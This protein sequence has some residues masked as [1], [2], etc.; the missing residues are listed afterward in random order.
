MTDTISIPT[1]EKRTEVLIVGAGPTGL[2]LALFLKKRGI[3]FRIIDRNQGPGTTSRAL[4]VQARTLEFYRQLGIDQKIISEGVLAKEL[5]FLRSGK[6]AVKVEFG[7]IG[8]GESPYPYLLFL[9]Q[10]VHEEILVQELARVGVEIERNTSLKEFKEIDNRVFAVLD[11]PKGEEKVQAD[12]L[13]GCD[14]AHSAVRHGMN[15]NFPGGTYAQVFFVAD[16][17][18][19]EERKEAVQVSVSR[20]DFCILMPIQQKASIRLTGLVPPGSENKTEIT[21]KDVSAAVQNNLGLSITKINWFSSYRVHHRVVDSFRKGR[22]FLAGDAAHIHSPAGGQGMNTGIGDAVNLAWKIAEVLRGSKIDNR[23]ELLLSSYNAERHT[24]ARV[25]VTTTDQAFQVIASRSWLG[26]I[27]RCYIIPTLLAYLVRSR[28]IGRLMFRT[29][30]QIRIQ[31]RNSPL[32]QPSTGTL[33]AGN[34]LPWLAYCDNFAPLQSFNWQ[35]HT[36]GAFGSRRSPDEIPHFDFPWNTEAERKGIIKG[37]QYLIRP[38][39]HIASIT[40]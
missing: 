39:G 18:A 12:F 28:A 26:G 16:V 38:D 40:S 9:S 17:E 24:F 36:Y 8:E 10:D 23:Q 32:T 3:R 5:H 34:R 11:G 14:G 2:V 6:L 37:S 33:Q 25:L 21:Y 27:V 35:T 31:Y 30:S 22:V 4:A 1:K 15:F 7:A 29:I 19:K 20:K 13:V